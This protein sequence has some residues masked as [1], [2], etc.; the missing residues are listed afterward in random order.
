MSKLPLVSVIIPA[1]NRRD[2]IDETVQ[3]VLKQTY[4]HVELIVVD[5]GSTDGTYE[6]LQEFQDR[7]LLLSHSGRL[8]KGQSIAINLGLSRA[9]G[10]YVAILD[11][12]DYWAEEKLFLQVDYL[13]RHENIGLVYGNG[14]CVDAKGNILY[15]FYDDLHYENNDPN[16]VLLDCYLLLPQ[17]AL[18]RKAVYEEVGFFEESFRA[19]Q[20][21]DML[22][23]IAEKTQFGYIPNYLFY[24]RRHGASI[25]FNGQE[26]RWK[27][28]FKILERAKNR[29]PYS[30][31]TI[32]KRLAVL[33]FR[34]GQVF[35]RKKQYLKSLPY[36]LKAGLL[37]PL[38]AFL[39][40]GGK[41]STN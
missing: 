8:N 23:R 40:I 27:N 19:A 28:G 25:S 41:E 36:L 11:S 13:M 26:Q 2:Y 1:F 14:Y 17:N 16:R 34:M 6:K 32:R 22:I 33:N 29:Y 15:P 37:D 5:D 38:R 10:E 39:V 30:S 35:W 18:V 9:K 20:D 21:H 4:P 24:Y 3:S 31:T 12:D 7:I